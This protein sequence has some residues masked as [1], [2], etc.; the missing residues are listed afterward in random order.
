M[1]RGVKAACL[2]LML[3]QGLTMGQAPPLADPGGPLPAAPLV[4]TTDGL[5]GIPI[6]PVGEPVIDG[7]AIRRGA[8]GASGAATLIPGVQMWLGAEYLM[9]FVSGSRVPIPLITSG[10]DSNAV[11]GALG[12]T[13]TQVLVGDQR[14]NNDP[15]HGIRMRFG[16]DLCDTGF[17]LEGVGFILDQ[18]VTSHV[19]PNQGQAPSVMGIPF[20]NSTM[21]TEGVAL[22]RFPEALEGSSEVKMR[23]NLSGWEVN[24]GYACNTYL[25]DWG[26]IGYRTL[27]LTE[28]LFI[29]NTIR[30][31][32]DD[33]ASF[34]GLPLAAGSTGTIADSFRTSNDF[35]G[36]QFG[37]V[38]R[39]I[40]RNVAF[41]GRASVAFGTTRQRVS[42]DG[43]STANG[44]DPV[45]GGLF[46]QGSNIGNTI[47]N[48]FSVI[49][50]VGASI[51]VQVFDCMVAYVG[52]NF[53][54]WNNV[55]RPGYE[56]D[57]KVNLTQV[58]YG[59]S[60]TTTLQPPQPGV[61]YQSSTDVIVHGLNAGLALQ[62]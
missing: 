15:Y 60:F 5:A 49:P 4:G 19:I 35:Y 57:R 2:A 26:F 31:L 50:E 21:N 16:I 11:S 7:G 28:G 38:K 45:Q 10:V 41:E 23:T 32:Q 14:F 39:L 62:F 13:G 42:I 37:A 1:G 34:Q 56:I 17:G 61:L 18:Q 55:A 12:Q 51:Y 3:S 46:A 53:L 8:A 25:V 29:N 59:P 40:Y 44:S 54:Y 33:L 22:I 43:Y 6:G 30:T 58:P 27:N 48:E 20:I 9:Y 52:Y 47:R 36:G 24:L